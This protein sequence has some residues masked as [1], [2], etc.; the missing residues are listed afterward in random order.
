MTI[1][2]LELAD[3]T[4]PIGTLVIRNLAEV[5]IAY[6]HDSLSAF[7]EKMQKSFGGL[8]VGERDEEDVAMLTESIGIASK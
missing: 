6:K 1:S 8:A 3:Q 7:F 2:I 4:R 5:I